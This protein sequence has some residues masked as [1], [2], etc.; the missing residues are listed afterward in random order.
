MARKCC[1]CRDRVIEFSSHG[2]INDDAVVVWS[3]WTTANEEYQKDGKS[4]TAEV[5]AKRIKRGSLGELKA[6][7]DESVK[8]V[9]AR[10]VY[11]HLRHQFIGVTNN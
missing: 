6:K 1:T 11:I 8:N 3:Q 7:F 4:K 2:V 5:T 9:L 10:H